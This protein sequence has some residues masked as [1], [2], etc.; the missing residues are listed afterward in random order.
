MRFLCSGYAFVM[1][2]DARAPVFVDRERGL[3]AQFRHEYFLVFLIA[4]LHMAA[5]LMLSHRA[6]S[7]VRRLNIESDDSVR[8]FRRET[9]QSKEIFLRFTHRYWF[10]EVSDKAQTRELFQK[11]EDHLGTERLYAEV[12]DELEDM[13]NYLD[14]DALRRQ[15]NTMIRLTV[16]TILGL[17]LTGVTVFLGMN[18]I[19]EADAGYFLKLVYFMATT[20]GFAVVVVC[21][22]LISRRL[23]EFLDVLTDDRLPGRRKWKAFLRVWRKR[24]SD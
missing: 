16:V 15:S 6:V 1:V 9:R 2:G 3:L 8:R 13:S 19:S 18:I 12:R 11:L 4:H 14:S 20:V 5:L 23:S 7:A 17:I 24:A 21:T 10:H 22:L